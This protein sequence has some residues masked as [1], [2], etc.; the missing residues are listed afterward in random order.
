MNRTIVLIG[1]VMYLHFQIYDK[2]DE[3]SIIYTRVR[4]MLKYYYDDIIHTC[5]VYVF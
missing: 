2:K 1:R 4:D 5:V 3:D